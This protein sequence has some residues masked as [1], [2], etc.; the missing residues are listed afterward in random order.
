MPILKSRFYVDRYRIRRM[1]FRERISPV[2][3]VFQRGNKV[4]IA[5]P[6]LKRADA[7]AECGRLLKASREAK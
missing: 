1:G 5:G 6:F 4:P 7:V 3:Y 2:V